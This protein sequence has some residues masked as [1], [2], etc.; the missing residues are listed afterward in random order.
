MKKRR[1]KPLYT[2][3][4]TVADKRKTKFR[5]VYT[6]FTFSEETFE[7][8]WTVDTILFRYSRYK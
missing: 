3:K 4:N 2:K 5:N 6:K 7:V 8:L 1:K